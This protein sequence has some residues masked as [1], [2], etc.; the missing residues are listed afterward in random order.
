MTRV[1]Q[2][3]SAIA[4]VRGCFCWLFANMCFAQCCLRCNF[5]WVCIAGVVVL[6]VDAIIRIVAAVAIS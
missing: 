3:D 2:T 5:V 6:V 4:Y 1:L